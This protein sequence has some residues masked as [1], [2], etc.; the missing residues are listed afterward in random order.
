MGLLDQLAGNLLGGNAGA[1]HSALLG[2]VLNSLGS[3]QG[4]GL[5]GLVQ[6]LASKGLGD[7][8][9]SWV[10]TGVNLPITAQQVQQVF[11]NPQIQQWA[12]Q[13]GLHPDAVAST[14]AKALP[15]LVDKLT[16]GGKLPD[17][18]SLAATLKSLLG[19]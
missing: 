12:A 14:L 1:S 17:A 16:P 5:A 7:V 15:G 6:T 3:S 4:G 2:T 11:G 13:H 18:A 9:Q 19:S 8:A 10:G